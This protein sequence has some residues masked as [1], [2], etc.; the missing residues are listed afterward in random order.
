MTVEYL[1][2]HRI[3][4]ASKC[5]TQQPLLIFRQQVFLAQPLGLCHVLPK[6]L[7]ISRAIV[8]RSII[9]NK[10]GSW[11]KRGGVAK[12]AKSLNVENGINV[13]DGI[14]WK[15]L[16]HNSNKRGEEGEKI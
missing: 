13:E 1:V 8:G 9:F 16:V 12:V 4:A 5:K 10:S 11:N 6:S 7:Y 14:F 2:K 3:T 15:K